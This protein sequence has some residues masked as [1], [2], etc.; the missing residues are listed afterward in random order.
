MLEKIIL[1]ADICI[2]LGGYKDARLQFIEMVIPKIAKKIYIHKYVYENEILVPKNA[3]VQVDRLISDKIISILDEG[4]L[5]G[6]ER[7]VYDASVEKLSKYM[8]N[9]NRPKK[10]LGEVKSIS[11]ANVKQIPYFMSDEGNLQT[12]IDKYINSGTKFDIKV[13]RISDMILAIKESNG[14]LGI[15]RKTAKIMWC[16]AVGVEHKDYFENKLW[17]NK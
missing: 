6:I 2:K 17:P 1:D 9:P 7:M 15:G 16:A 14:N 12:I 11:M 4:C 8:I 5:S 13:F 10:N 3:K